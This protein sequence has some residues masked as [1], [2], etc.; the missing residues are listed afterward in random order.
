MAK[1]SRVDASVATFMLVQ[2]G[3]VMHTI[4]ALGSEAQKRYWLPKLAKLEV[5]GGWGLT[6]PEN[7]SDAA[8]IKTRAEQVGER[9][10]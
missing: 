7:G 10:V 4:G 2:S 1:V 8:N 9:C 3:L 5:I 6:E